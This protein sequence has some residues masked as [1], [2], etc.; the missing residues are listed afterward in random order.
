ML[1]LLSHA[2]LNIL[3]NGPVRLSGCIHQ[4]KAKGVVVFRSFS[5]LSPPVDPPQAWPV[6]KMSVTVSHLGQYHAYTLCFAN[7]VTV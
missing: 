3:N 2:L 6:R 5:W 4:P 7:K 1:V